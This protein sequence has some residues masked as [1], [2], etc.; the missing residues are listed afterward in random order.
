MLKGNYCVESNDTQPTNAVSEHPVYRRGTPGKLDGVTDP[1][2]QSEE[3]RKRRPNLKDEV[4]SMLRDEILSG[5]LR[6][7]Q[8]IDQDGIAERL[9]V[10]K[11]PVREALIA[12]ESETLVQTFARR[13]AFVAPLT[14]A[15][16]L[17][18][19]AMYGLITGLAA[20]RA[21]AQ[22]SSDEM[23]E[24]T[25]LVHRMESESD[26]SL[27]ETLNFRFH[28]IINR[29]GASRRLISVITVLSK[30]I[31]NHFFEFTPA[32][33]DAARDDHRRILAA[34]VDG[35]ALAAASAMNEHLRRG[36]VHAVRHLE[37]VGF[38]DDVPGAPGKPTKKE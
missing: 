36:G 30:S 34:L 16:V 35:D 19:Y 7:G 28:Q 29:A 22:L 20:E 33:S 4:A 38:W 9:G 25:E 31:P 15:D 10:S 2:V 32:W 13:G 12:L 6:P 3:L 23:A 17:D 18:H 24:L 1:I 21:T 8:K 5:R 26:Q 27:Q 11:L 14:R 37:S